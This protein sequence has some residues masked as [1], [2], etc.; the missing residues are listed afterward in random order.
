MSNEMAINTYL[1]R[2]ESKKTKQTRKNRN[3]LI[4]IENILM[5]DKSEG[6]WGDGEKR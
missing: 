5:V 3:R 1:S 2:N 6:G 4:D